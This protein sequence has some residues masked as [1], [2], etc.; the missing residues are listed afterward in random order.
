MGALDAVLPL[1]S[2]LLGAG[3][4][5]SVNVRVRRRTYVEDLFN[6]AIAAVAA[7]E[8]SVNYLSGTGRPQHLDDREYEELQKWMVTEGLKNWTIKCAAAGE[9]L[10]RVLP[11]HDELASLLPFQPD[12]DNRTAAETIAVLKRG[13]AARQRRATTTR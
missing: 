10:A 8:A 7:A 13:L 1:A 5:Y 11:Y 3:I 4:T 12:T 2:T 6:Q 9:A